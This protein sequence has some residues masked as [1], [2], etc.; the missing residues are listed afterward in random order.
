MSRVLTEQ[1]IN[2]TRGITEAQ[3]DNAVD[4]YEQGLSVAA[5][6]NQRGFDNPTILK[7][8]RTRGVTI[9]PAA[10]QRPEGMSD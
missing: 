7:A 3:I 4:L 5:V 10:A 9:R 6:I 2:A 1:D 8:C